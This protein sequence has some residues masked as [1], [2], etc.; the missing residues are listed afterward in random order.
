MINWL[1]GFVLRHEWLF[2][3]VYRYRCPYS[4]G[5]LKSARACFE[6]GVCGCDNARRF[7]CPQKR[8]KRA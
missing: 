7:D 6:A 2:R 3:I 5:D 1:N 4:I 8:G